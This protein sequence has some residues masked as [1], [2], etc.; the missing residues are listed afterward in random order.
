MVFSNLFWMATYEIA[1]ICLQ[2][3]M[4]CGTFVENGTIPC[5][6]GYICYENTYC[7]TQV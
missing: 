1:R 6:E 5:C 4:K 3:G 2:E 7:I